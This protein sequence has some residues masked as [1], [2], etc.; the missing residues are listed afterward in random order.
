MIKKMIRKVDGVSYAR[1]LVKTHQIV[2]GEDLFPVLKK[3]AFPKLQ[4]GDWVAVSEKVVSVCQNNVRHLS[5]V[6]ANWLAKLIV[7]GVKKYPND[8]GFSRPEKMQ[9]AVERAGYPRII[10]AMILGSIGKLFGLR[11]IFWIVAGHRISEIDGF[12]PAAMYPYPEYVMLP[13]EE[14][15]KVVQ[16][17]EEKLGY[18]VAMVDGTNVNVEVIAQSS[19]IKL[20]R[21]T[22]QRILLDNPQGQGPELTPFIIVREV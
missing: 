3:Y 4:P 13:P 5:T 8:I 16:E 11:G 22:V 1:I 17:L 21:K 9:V 15:N 10:L 20:D 12:N 6:R 18:P 19:G 7:K 2:F 14:P